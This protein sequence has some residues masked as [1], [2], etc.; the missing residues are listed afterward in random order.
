MRVSLLLLLTLGYLPVAA[1]IDAGQEAARLLEA[2]R[3]TYPAMRPHVFF[4]QDKYAPG[5]TAFF[6][7]FILTE[8]ERILATRALFTVELV[9]KQGEAILRQVVIGQ[10][11]GAAN[12]LILPGH[13]DPGNYEVR[14]FS[15][16][17]TVAYG[18][19]ASLR[20]VNTKPVS[21]V[22]PEDPRITVHPEGGNLVPGVLNRVILRSVGSE[23][24]Q[25]RL[26]SDDGRV[27]SVNFDEGLASVQ[28]IPMADKSY[29]LEYE[30]N[31]TTRRTVFPPA[32]R[33][34]ATMRLYAGPKKTRVIDLS[35]GPKA[36][37]NGILILVAGRQV[38]HQ[39]AIRFNADGKANLL[40]AEGFFPEG[41]S[42][43]YLV[44]ETLKPLAYRPVYIP[45]TPQ[46][47]VTIDELPA[48]TQ[49]RNEV[50]VSVKV[51][52]AAGQP[53][54]SS[55]TIS[56]IPEE[57]RLRPLRTPDPTLELRNA[58]PAWDWTASEARVEMEVLTAYSLPS[59][60]VPDFPVLLHTGSL[61]LSGRAYAAD[62]SET[63]PYMSRMVI[64]LHHD[65]IQYETAIDGSGN[66]HFEKIYDFLGTDQVF[67]KVIDQNNRTIRARVDWSANFGGEIP[68]SLE[69]YESTEGE[70][71]YGTIRERRRA[72]GRS[73]N[74]F[75]S[76]DSNSRGMMNLNMAIEQ[77]FGGADIEIRPSEYVTFGTMRELILEVIP[78]LKF[79]V[80]GKDSVVVVSPLMT[81][82]PAFTPM[83][84]AEGDP[85]YVIDGC[86]TT[87]TRFL[88]SLSPRDIEVVRIIN[89]IVKLDKLQ[90]LAR[91]GVLFIQ[92]R[93]PEQTRSVLEKELYPM[94]GLSP[95]LA[96][97]S[98]F[99]TQKRVPD[100]RS[101]LYWTPLT[102]TDTTG[103]ARITF[104]TSDLP[105]PYWVRIMGVTSTGHLFSTE[106]RFEVKF[107]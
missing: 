98:K 43:L 16:R 56:V 47:T 82:S 34:S 63:L 74:Y 49:L 14:I 104:R 78:A 77:A 79:R 84:Y 65:L 67:Y 22:K 4:S 92:T 10:P 32:E 27:A 85:L 83:R 18:A 7:L 91:D 38:A 11:F 29:F 17:M 105:G 89:D 15:D 12:Q 48:M 71:N 64:Y 42:E 53:V 9:N 106:Q 3:T 75:L 76:P 95:T 59:R 46:A 90:N 25:A 2:N 20:I 58:P 96:M 97:A 72:I 39:Q 81:S 103:Q 62:P 60:L 86:L 68:F 50:N 80:H 51:T 66:F 8:T 100:L 107:K 44:D 24:K 19:I 13:L 93:I 40:V 99:P 73:F 23:L 102:D 70:D 52:D 87:N 26:S 35:S 30:W 37:R 69:P 101:T 33:H 88:M 57:A 55:L 36:P 1:Q 6:R 61:S 28:F 21:K 31:G 41:L 5:D 45:P 54:Q 94:A